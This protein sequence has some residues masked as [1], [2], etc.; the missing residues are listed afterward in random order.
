[1]NHQGEVIFEHGG[2]RWRC[3]CG[4]QAQSVAATEAMAEKAHQAH[5]KRATKD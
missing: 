3:K 4:T 1:M 2:H 5:R